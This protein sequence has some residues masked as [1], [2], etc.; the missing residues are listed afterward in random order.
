MERTIVNPVFK[1]VCPFLQ[2][3]A[4]TNGRLSEL[5][6]T[7]GPGGGNP[8]HRH[9]GFTETFTAIEGNLGLSLI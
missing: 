9:T 4:E 7:L 8:L 6:V 5:E 2:T 3:S 1:D